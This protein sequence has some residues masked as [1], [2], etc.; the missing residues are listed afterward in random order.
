MFNKLISF[1]SSKKELLPSSSGSEKVAGVRAHQHKNLKRPVE[2]HNSVAQPSRPQQIN[3]IRSVFTEKEFPKGEWSI[4][5]GPGGTITVNEGARKNIA[6]MEL[7]GAGERKI[8][9]VVVKSNCYGDSVY[10]DVKSQL[11]AHKYRVLEIL[12]SDAGFIGK[13]YDS[14]SASNNVSDSS[15]QAAFALIEKVPSNKADANK[16]LVLIIEITSV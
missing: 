14:S 10:L 16:A 7:V 9:I 11:V 1:L 13:L 6:I 8:C 2:Q 3:A 4:I 15:S 5:S 12:F